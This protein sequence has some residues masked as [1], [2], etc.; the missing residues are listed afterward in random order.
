MASIPDVADSSTLDVLLKRRLW[1]YL[2]THC[3]FIEHLLQHSRC[4]CW[5]YTQ[6]HFCIY[7][8][9]PARV[10]LL[11]TLLEH[12]RLEG[13]HS[14][15]RSFHN[16]RCSLEMKPLKISQDTLLFYCTPAAT[17]P[18]FMSAIHTTT[19]KYSLSAAMYFCQREY[20]KHSWNTLD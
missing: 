6:S 12:F 10:Q 7:T 19:F 8:L 11:E 14:G 1:K 3:S 17:C 16:P 4:F 2:R 20:C 5:L 13:F 9:L 18:M 15:H